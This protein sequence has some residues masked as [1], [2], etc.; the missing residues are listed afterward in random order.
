VFVVGTAAVK[1]GDPASS[2]EHASTS[3][4]DDASVAVALAVGL[5]VIVAI[6]VVIFIAVMVR[7]VQSSRQKKAADR[8]H[9]AAIAGAGSARVR[10]SWGFDSIRSK[11]SITSEDSVNA[12]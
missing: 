3:A 2:A 7:H 11:Y 4:G 1:G 8:Q 5:G 9:S 6:L 12:Q 10:Q